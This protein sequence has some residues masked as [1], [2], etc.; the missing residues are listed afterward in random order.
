MTCQS[1]RRIHESTALEA[2]ANPPPCPVERPGRDLLPSLDFL[3]LHARRRE[4]AWGKERVYVL[5]LA[6]L[7][8]AFVF[9]AL[10]VAILFL[11]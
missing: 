7:L 6:F 10:Y 11:E 5:T 3:D 4:S 8:G 2:L 9:G 1:E